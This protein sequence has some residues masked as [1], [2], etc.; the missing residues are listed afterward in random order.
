MYNSHRRSSSGPSM[1]Q[2]TVPLGPY[3]SLI[4]VRSQVPVSDH[5]SNHLHWISEKIQVSIYQ[6]GVR[7]CWNRKT[8]LGVCQVIL[9]T[10]FSLEVLSRNMVYRFHNLKFVVIYDYGPCP[11][12]PSGIHALKLWLT[13]LSNLLILRTDWMLLLLISVL[14]SIISKLFS[15]SLFVLRATFQRLRDYFK[16]RLSF[17]YWLLYCYSL[18]L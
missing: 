10:R 15:S 8:R 4:H 6:L 12:L 2:Q 11:L 5:S 7:R 9:W 17:L 16:I 1:A 14:S 3:S 13:S 18:L